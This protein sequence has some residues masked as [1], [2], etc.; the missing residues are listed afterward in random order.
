MRVQG[1]GCSSERRFFWRRRGLRKKKTMQ[2]QYVADPASLYLHSAEFQCSHAPTVGDAGGQRMFVFRPPVP[3]SSFRSK[4]PRISKQ[5][6]RISDTPGPGYYDHEADE[7]HVAEDAVVK[8]APF[9]STSARIPSTP[10]GDGPCDFSTCEPDFQR[11]PPRSGVVI[12]FGATSPARG[13]YGSLTYKSEAAEKEKA[14]YSPGPGAHDSTAPVNACGQRTAS[15]RAT[16]RDSLQGSEHWTREQL[17]RLNLMTQA[18]LEAHHADFASESQS[19]DIEVSEGTSVSVPLR[20]GRRQ[21][22]NEAFLATR[23]RFAPTRWCQ[24]SPGPGAYCPRVM[25]SPCSPVHDF[26]ASEARW[27]RPASVGECA[28]ES[29]STLPKA[30]APAPLVGCGPECRRVVSR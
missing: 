25:D 13:V 2:Q 1:L 21:P 10:L 19:R 22:A 11:A 27:K 29:L 7:E 17:T 6:L 8:R 20:A 30:V 5:T 15:Q 14:W 26:G 12:G 24:S 23:E 18:A 9:G 4:S 3:S 28:R 16:A